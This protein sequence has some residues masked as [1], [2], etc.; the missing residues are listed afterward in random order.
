MTTNEERTIVR[1]IEL[2]AAPDRVWRAITDAQELA[3]WFPDRAELDL[4]PGGR[5]SLGWDQHG[6]FPVHVEAVDA[7]RYLAW[8][9]AG[10]DGRPIE[11]YSTRVEWTLTPRPDGGT[12]LT[13][14]ESGFD[15][16]RHAEENT[17]GWKEELGHL[18]RHLSAAA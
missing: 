7:P 10:N 12:T 13:V 8:R 4:R 1:T 5:G 9:W 6:D 3:S 11:E 15:S 14:R 16:D 18:V 2:D 17:N